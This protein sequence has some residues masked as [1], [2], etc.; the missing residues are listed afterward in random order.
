MVLSVVIY[1]H[2]LTLGQWFGA[3]VVFAGISVEVWVKRRGTLVSAAVAAFAER[4]R[5]DV[6]AKRVIAEQEKAKIKSL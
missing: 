2:T 6:H 1:N 3:M 4:L 5:P